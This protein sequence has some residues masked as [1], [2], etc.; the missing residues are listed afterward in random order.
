MLGS[1]GC[2]GGVR[3]I[4]MSR[5]VWDSLETRRHELGC[6][7]TSKTHSESDVARDVV[8]PVSH[9]ISHDIQNREVGKT[10]ALY[11][12]ARDFPH[13]MSHDVWKS[14]SLGFH[15]LNDAAEFLV[16]T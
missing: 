11:D 9:G 12:A 5:G 7:K 8:E 6:R 13:G 3:L 16:T 2:F 14:A 10:R 1:F 4:T 15:I